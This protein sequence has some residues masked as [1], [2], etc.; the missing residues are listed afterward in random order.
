MQCL[1][2]WDLQYSCQRKLFHRIS[3]S[4]GRY[5]FMNQNLIVFYK[6]NRLPLFFIFQVI[7]FIVLRF[8]YLKLAIIYAN[9][10]RPGMEVFQGF[11]LFFLLYSFVITL[12]IISCL[13]TGIYLCISILNKKIHVG[14][15]SV[16]L[17]VLVLFFT[18]Y[19]YIIPVF[20]YRLAIA[21]FWR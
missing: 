5:R 12:L 18:T 21:K 7:L 4:K 2:I 17:L 3:Y 15:I 16:L 11:E 14:W 9:K 1:V 6:H 8:F 13:I 19:S 20:F 10:G